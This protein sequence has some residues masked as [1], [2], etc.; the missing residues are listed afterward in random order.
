MVGIAV[1]T[2]V[3]EAT[4]LLVATVMSLSLPFIVLLIR[5]TSVTGVSDRC[6]RLGASDA[7][8]KS[9][10]GGLSWYLEI[11]LAARYE[12]ATLLRFIEDMKWPSCQQSRIAIARLATTLH[13]FITS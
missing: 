4:L 5:L 11:I 12:E 9:K 13:R 6:P 1:G 7:A 8:P 3:E 2:S 10:S